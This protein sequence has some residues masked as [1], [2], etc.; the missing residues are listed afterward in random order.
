[1]KYF[2]R[3][4]GIVIIV[5]MLISLTAIADND[6]Y[7]LPAYKIKDK[8]NSEIWRSPIIFDN[9]G[10]FVYFIKP[11]DN[12]FAGKTT[13][14]KSNTD[15]NEETQ[16]SKLISGRYAYPAISIDG[17]KLNLIATRT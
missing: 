1:M 12:G 14:W 6:T 3:L 2:S 9:V 16:I 11:G 15:T 10:K 13:F 4:T 17:K 5:L 7:S 8:I